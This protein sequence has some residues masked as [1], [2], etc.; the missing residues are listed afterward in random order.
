MRKLIVTAALALA[1]S[2]ASAQIYGVQTLA[3]LRGCGG[4]SASSECFGAALLRPFARGGG[5]GRAVAS[6]GFVETRDIA[7]K[8][9]TASASGS[10]GGNLRLPVLHAMS[11]AAPNN[12]RVNGSA[13]GF[14]DYTYRGETGTAFS[15]RSTLTV[16][17]SSASPENPF[18]P[19]GSVV[20]FLIAIFDYD[21]FQNLYVAP[22]A[23]SVSAPNYVDCSTPGVLGFGFADPNG[24]GG[25]FSVS[26][27]TQACGTGS[28][29][30][31][32]GQRVVT[33]SNLS[34][35]TNR[36]GLLDASHTLVTELD[37]TLD[38]ASVAALQANLAPGVPE[39]AQWALMIG[40]F[41]MVG[42]ALRRP[43][44]IAATA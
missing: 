36:G 38:A 17:A 31:S 18:L 21:A 44:A 35:F 20:T 41:G 7:Q 34:L 13:L 28:L 27:T 11:Y 30:L 33:Y 14:L 43:R 2:P 23:T 22:G 29:N 12:A 3:S 32:R 37:P 5:I 24:T 42:G 40:G 8:G 1:A 26:A 4:V 9:S 15:L 25:S 6:S 16:E 39:P 10:L 19:N